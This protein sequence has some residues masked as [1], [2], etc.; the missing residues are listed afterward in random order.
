[1]LLIPRYYEV[2][3]NVKRGDVRGDVYM[4]F[5]KEL[6]KLPEDSF[7]EAF[8]DGCVFYNEGVTGNVSTSWCI[9][10]P[11]GVEIRYY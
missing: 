11:Y 10:V 6:D 8:Y 1:M 5:E 2:I 9:F 3:E 7:N 4:V